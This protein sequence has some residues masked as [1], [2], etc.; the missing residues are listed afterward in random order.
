MKF[1]QHIEITP[2]TCGGKPRIKGTRIRV[3]DIVNWHYKS[4]LSP[5]DIVASYPHLSLASIYAALA[6][7]HDNKD[8]IDKQIKDSFDFINT[9]KE[10]SNC[11]LNRENQ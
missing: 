5:C 4:R 6:F 10:R 3:Q 8:A 2:D 1:N 11:K 9:L 7:Y